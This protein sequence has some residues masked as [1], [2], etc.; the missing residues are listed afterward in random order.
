MHICKSCCYSHCYDEDRDEYN[1]EKVENLFRQIDRP[2]IHYLWEGAIKE[3][4]TRFGSDTIKGVLG[5]YCKTINMSQYKTLGWLDSE[6]W[7]LKYAGRAAPFTKAENLKNPDSKG[8]QVHD[9]DFEV[10]DEMIMLFGEN[11][12]AREYKMMFDKYEFLKQ[13]YPSITNLHLESLVTY[14]RF[15]VKEELAT[16]QNSIADAA[17][18]GELAQKAAD[19][20]KINPSQ[21]SQSDLQGGLNSFSELFMAVEQAVDIIPI[22][23]QFKYRPNDAPDFIIWCFINYVRSAEGKP[24][25]EYEDI[26]RFYDERKREYIE[27]YGDPYGIFRDDPTLENRPKIEQFIDLPP[28]FEDD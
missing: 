16:A 13:N 15:K 25:C 12:S 23:P 2:F 5:M 17:K 20:A 4:K 28:D 1:M 6:E 11:Y 22:L 24:L 26:Y 3:A 8:F 9:P 14:V 18:W 27:Q 10:T 19:K 7:N 21:L